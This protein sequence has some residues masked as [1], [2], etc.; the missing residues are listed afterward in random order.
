[1][2]QKLA[3]YKS[4]F[5]YSVAKKLLMAL[6]G[7]FMVTFL[8]AHLSGNLQLLYNDGGMAFNIY[9]KFMTTFPLV[10]IISY[11]LY[12]SILLHVIDGFY[13]AFK[14]KKARPVDYAVSNAQK[15]SPWYSR[16]MALLGSLILFFLVIHL[17]KFWFQMHWGDVPMVMY[18]G[19]EYKDL[20]SLVFTAYKNP[21]WVVFYVLAMIP[22]A[23]HLLHGFQSG[24][25]TLGLNHSTYT[26]IIKMLGIF[27]SVVIPIGFAAIPVLFFLT[28]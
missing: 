17:Y 2:V 25:Q 24:F 20:Y 13:L 4:F 9:A 8:V 19:E 15:N 6:T 7:I 26:P 10:K 3:Q 11:V 12:I 23:Y 27:I 16:S 28:K 21:V 14:N 1:M 22:L 18:D 5:T